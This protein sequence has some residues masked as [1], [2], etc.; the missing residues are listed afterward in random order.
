MLKEFYFD[1][2]SRVKV[3]SLNRLDLTRS[4]KTV[5]QSILLK[6]KLGSVIGDNEVLELVNSF[7]FSWLILI[8][9]MN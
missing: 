2:I 3:D 4:L 8:M 1:V 7:I 5:Y 6:E 9:I